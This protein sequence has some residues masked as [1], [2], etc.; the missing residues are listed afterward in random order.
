MR[1]TAWEAKMGKISIIL[2]MAYLL[3]STASLAQDGWVGAT[4]VSEEPTAPTFNRCLYQTLDGYRFTIIVNGPCPI[5]VLV[6]PRTGE[7]NPN[8]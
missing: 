6:N 5:S 3:L 8:K 4:L 1:R 2:S 7:V